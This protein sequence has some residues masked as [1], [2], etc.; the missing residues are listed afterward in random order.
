MSVPY[1]IRKQQTLTVIPEMAKEVIFWC[2]VF[3]AVVTSA[4]LIGQIGSDWQ[5][6][7]PSRALALAAASMSATEQVDAPEASDAA[8]LNASEADEPSATF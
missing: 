1:E 3:V 8:P 5:I 4:V 2:A 7:V 6:P